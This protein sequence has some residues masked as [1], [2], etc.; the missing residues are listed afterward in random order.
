MKLLEELLSNNAQS[1]VKLLSNMMTRHLEN[2]ATIF[3]DK[4]VEIR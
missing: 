1:F 2:K 4:D 3:P